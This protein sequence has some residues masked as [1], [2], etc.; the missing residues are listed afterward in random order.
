TATQCEATGILCPQGSHCAAAQPICISDMNLCGNAHLDQPIR[1][2]NGN[3][4]LKDPRNE[5]CDDGNNI[6]GDGC[7]ADCRSTENCGN[8]KIDPGEE[9][10]DGKTP[11]GVS[12]NAND[13]DCRADCTINRC[14]DGFA[15]THG[16]HREACDGAPQAPVH[17][18]TT[19]PTETAICNAD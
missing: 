13:R 14:G 11:E 18:R 3:P 1:D 7:S 12:N 8:G 4:D 10:D 19:R 15:N 9:C 6:D 2:A 16:S 5:I 17:D